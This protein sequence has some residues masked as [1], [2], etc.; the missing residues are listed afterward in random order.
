[1]TEKSALA[2]TEINRIAALVIPPI[3][4]ERILTDNSRRENN[5]IPTL[6]GFIGRR[7]NAAGFRKTEIAK[8]FRQDYNTM[9]SQMI[10]CGKRATET[11]FSNIKNV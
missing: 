1:M 8:L 4:P 6:R 10:R 5:L 3:P 11:R 7:L 9:D 2:L